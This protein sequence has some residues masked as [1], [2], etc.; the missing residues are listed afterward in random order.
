MRT[1]VVTF[2]TEFTGLEKNTELISIGLVAGD[3]NFY[4]E[5]TDYDETKVDDW[6]KSNVI[7]N[8]FC[9]SLRPDEYEGINYHRGTK[10]EIKEKLTEWFER[11]KRKYNAYIIQLVSD[12]CHYD[13]V[14]LIDLF[15]S[16]FN[17]PKFIS[18]VCHDINKDIADL[19]KLNE[20][21]AFDISREELLKIKA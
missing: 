14:L 16:A 11:M 12:V 20:F 1:L 2:D 5:F 6:I 18:P 4:A 9:N 8:L 10:E 19:Y 15:G 7:D 17:L 13:M 21:K 3:D